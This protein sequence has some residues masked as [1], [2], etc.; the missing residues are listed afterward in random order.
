MRAMH[1]AFGVEEFFLA[2]AAGAHFFRHLPDTGAGAELAAAV[3]TVEHGAAGHA[4]GGHVARCGAHQQRR[5]G[6]VAAHQQHHAVERIAADRLFHIHAGEIAKQHGGRPQQGFAERHDRELQRKAA[7]FIDADLDLLGKRAEMGIA[8]GQFGKGIA[9]TDDGPAV[10][11]VMRN[12]A[13]LQ[14]GPVNEAVTV[15]PAEPCLAAARRVFLVVH[16][17]SCFCFIL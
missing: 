12:A 16:P 15:L 9:D 3:F 8:R 4:Y 14:P 6:L 7:G 13:V 17:V 11:L 5:R 10:E 2:H 1:A